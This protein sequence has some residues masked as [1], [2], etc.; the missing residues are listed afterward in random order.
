MGKLIN[1]GFALA[2]IVLAGLDAHRHQWGWLAFDAGMVLLSLTLL[3]IAELKP[4]K[5][6]A[7]VLGEFVGRPCGNPANQ[8]TNLE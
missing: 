4:P 8:T 3:A 1:E 5:L 6:Q 2:W 7:G